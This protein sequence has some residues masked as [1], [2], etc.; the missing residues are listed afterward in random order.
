PPP[1]PPPA[2][3]GP[4][5]ARTDPGVRAAPSR[6]HRRRRQ[7]ASHHVRSH[8]PR[9]YATATPPVLPALR[10]AAPRSLPQRDEVPAPAL[11]R[12]EQALV[13]QLVTVPFVGGVGEQLG[14]PPRPAAKL[15]PGQRQP[16]L[17][18]IGGEVDDRD[19][20]TGAVGPAPGGAVS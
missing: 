13:D 17:G 12:D 15:G 16:A 7:A 11:Q 19:V 5:P 1:P 6:P 3:P 10:R 14:Q 2:R 20:G 8:G 9:A 18:R 4:P